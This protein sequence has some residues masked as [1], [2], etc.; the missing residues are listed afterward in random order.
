MK[1]N[2]DELDKLFEENRLDTIIEKTSES[3]DLKSLFYRISSFIML[4]KYDDALNC[5][6]KNKSVLMDDLPS[7]IKVHI[8]LLC[9]MNKYDEAYE[10]AKVYSN[11][12]YHSQEVEEILR[13]LNKNIREHERRNN[14]NSVDVTSAIEKLKDFKNLDFNEI[15]TY[16]DCLNNLGEHMD[17]IAPILKE[18]KNIYARAYILLALN[19]ENYTFDVSYLSN[20]KKIININPSKLTTPYF[21]SVG[22]EV[23]KKLDDKDKT[24]EKVAKDIFFYYTTYILPDEFKGDVDKM[25]EVI[26]FKAHQLIGN[27][28]C[29]LSNHSDEQ[30]QNYLKEVEDA[31]KNI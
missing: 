24:I 17:V 23:Y 28:D 25:V 16:I 30:I 19:K 22:L 18:Y 3:K 29:S 27:K 12:P 5:I 13:N 11:L 10:E 8:D 1:K 21:G 20:D 9:E 15:L 31:L 4:E 6:N 26:K 7:L 14:A 2:L